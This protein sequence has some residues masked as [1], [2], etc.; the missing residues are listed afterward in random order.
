MRWP[1]SK[2]AAGPEI[3]S[4]SNPGAELLSIFGGTV[5]GRIST[6]QALTVPAVSAAIRLIAESAATL[7]VCVKKPAGDS[8]VDAPDHP[9][10]KLLRGQ[11]NAWT[12]GFE[13]IRDITAQALISDNGGLAYVTKVRREPREVIHYRPSYMTVE[14]DAASGEPTYRLDN[15]PVP[16]KNVIHVRGPFAKSPLNLAIDAITAAKQMETYVSS[17]FRN[18]ARPGGFLSTEQTMNGPALENIKAIWQS[19]FGGG[20]N[21]GKTPIL[22]EGMKFETLS[23]K[24]TDAEFTVN[25]TFQLNEIARAFRVPPGM[26]YEMSRQ[27]W[28]NMEQASREFISTSLEPWLCSLEAA[29]NRA[30]LTAEELAAGYR[31]AFDR[32]DTS[33]AD[34]TARATAI[35]SLIASKVL[36][37]NEARDWL[38]MP[39]YDG[40]AEYANPHV[41]S[42]TAGNPTASNDNKPPEVTNDATRAA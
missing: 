34:L 1:F 20:D 3:K 26:I 10:L 9:A 11:A 33:R 6:E 16:A 12:S 27:T 35:S 13:L 39:P 31:I 32:D 25:R 2:K 42:P 36:N 14:Y 17:M 38:G 7:H 5:P 19:A 41:G 24:S 21:A 40:G 23:M 8:E 37:P 29:F 28:S 4:L 22:P 30:L 18:G 15:Q